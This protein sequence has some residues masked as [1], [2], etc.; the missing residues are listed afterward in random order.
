M[1]TRVNG[2]GIA[3]LA[4]AL[5]LAGSAQA[6][7][8]E[9]SNPAPS[10]PIPLGRDQA[11]HATRSGARVGND[12]APD[13]SPGVDTGSRMPIPNDRNGTVDAQPQGRERHQGGQDDQAQDAD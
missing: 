6:D 2:R 11:P 4:G 9:R 7:K 1:N 13:I 12:A 8:L 3:V 5:L 10:D